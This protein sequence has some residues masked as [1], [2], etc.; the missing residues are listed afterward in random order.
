MNHYSIV[1]KAYN[2]QIITFESRKSCSKVIDI[3]AALWSKIKMGTIDSN[4]L[5]QSVIPESK[6]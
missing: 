2:I 1:P 5:I 3:M 4:H 6:C